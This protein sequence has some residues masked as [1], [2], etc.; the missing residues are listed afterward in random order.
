MTE[1]SDKVGDKVG[2]EAG[3]EVRAAR[4]G[5]LIFTNGHLHQRQCRHGVML[6]NVNDQFQ[7]RML[8]KYGEYS[9][10]EVDTFAQLLKPGMTAVE[11]GANIGSHT[12]AIA[13]MVGPQGRVLA[14]EPQRAIFQ[15]LCANTALNA[16][17]QVEPYWMAVGA[18]AGEVIIDRLDMRAVQN[19]GG[20]SIGAAKVGDKVPLRTLDS[21]ELPACHMIKI[22]VEGMEADVIRGAAA[23]I[24]RC[25]PMVFC[26]N[27][28]SEKSP[29]LIQLLWDLDYDCYWHVTPYVRVP[30][31]RGDPEKIHGTMVSTNMVCVP[32]KAQAQITG[33]HK[34]WRVDQDRQ[35]LWVDGLG[36][37]HSPV[38]LLSDDIAALYDSA[39]KLEGLNF[40]ESARDYC[41]RILELQPDH[42]QALAK[43]DELLKKQAGA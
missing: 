24:R 3:A 12:V 11:V 33:L 38:P 7:G 37:F 9:E 21:F 29:E 35:R 2:D 17:E 34:V 6:Y 10:G 14:F 30:N 4:P 5:E 19:F 39:L 42:P 40:V 36:N 28:S 22:D 16:L 13:H 32:R 31:Y 43:R 27:E 20:Y 18:A 41:N 23:T 8:D 15:V 25:G 1:V 26:E